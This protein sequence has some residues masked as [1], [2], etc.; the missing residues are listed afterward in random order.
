MK[1][2][3]DKIFSLK[4]ATALA[5]G[6]LGVI[7]MGWPFFRFITYAGNRKPLAYKKP[8]EGKQNRK[9]WFA[10]KH[11]T[12]NHPKNGYEEEYNLTRSWCEAQPMTDWFLRSHDGLLLHA[13]YYPVE[14]ARRF[15]ILCH[16]YRGTRFGSVAHIAKFLREEKCNLLFIDQRCCGES[17]GSYITF[18]AKEQRDI[19]DWVHRVL[20]ENPA[21]LPI[22]LYGQSMGATSV[23]LAS[24]HKLPREVRGLIADCGF[25]SMRGQIRDIA[26]GWFRFTLIDV[27]LLRTDLLCRIFAGFSMRQTDTKK[28]LR[29]N[30]LPVLFF[31]GAEDT[32]VWPHNTVQNFERCRAE[33]EMVIVPG[34]RHLC[35]SYVDPKLYQEKLLSFFKKHDARTGR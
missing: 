27:A 33:R 3:L 1:T 31:H 17:E 2:P 10:L 30:V 11:T 23:L 6:S 25:T 34:A 21:R 24:G 13:S 19:R 29:K 5:A 20:L 15:V 12:V 26:S 28:A 7:S 35:C 14:D 4:A 18:G 22:Y 8:T 16:G 9:K 32:Y